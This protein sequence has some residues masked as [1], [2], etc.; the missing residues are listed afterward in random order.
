M[1]YLRGKKI[2]I[3][4]L[5]NM[6]SAILNG[7][8]SSRAVGKAALIGF[9]KEPARR[10]GAR[11]KYSIPISRSVSELVTHCDIVIIAV[12]PQNIGEVLKEISFYGKGRLYISIAAGITTRRIEKALGGKPRV[13]RVMPNTPALVG[14]GISALCKGRYASK[15]DLKTA[16]EIFSSVGEAVELNEKYF[17]LVTALSG[18]G[19][20]YFFYLKEA[21]IGAAVR[22]G[23]DNKTAKK[24][25]LQTALGSARLLLESG[26]EH[27]LLRQHVTSKGGTT[28][29]A[30]AVFEKAKIKET[31]AR[32]VRA[33][34]RRSKELSRD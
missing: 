10:A 6:G 27:G 25:V 9:D 14:E 34:A 12:K 13:I 17:D 26:H 23:M 29:R 19:P 5:G 11:K 3:I 18:S 22:L 15:S 31:V 8:I 28:E 24:L 33:A 32:A 1:R 2:G 30:I 4:G 16:D 7:L 21:L 20:A